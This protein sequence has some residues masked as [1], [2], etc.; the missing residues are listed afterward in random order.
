MVLALN[1]RNLPRRVELYGSIFEHDWSQ[2]SMYNFSINR[3]SNGRVYRDTARV[4][5]LIGWSLK[6]N[7]GY[8]SE[9]ICPKEILVSKVEKHLVEKI[10]FVTRQFLKK[11]AFPHHLQQRFGISRI[12]GLYGKFQNAVVNHGE[13][14]IFFFKKCLV[15]KNIFST[16]FLIFETIFLGHISSEM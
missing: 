2:Q 16:F 15:T 13:K 9:D 7:P 1:P 6:F 11:Y 10:F 8:I 3:G 12:V 14:H 5:L 4:L